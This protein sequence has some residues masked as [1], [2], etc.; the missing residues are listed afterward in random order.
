MFRL[1]EHHTTV[2][3][4]VRGGLVTFLTL[5]YI[6]FVQPAVMGA[7]GMPPG[8]V[9]VA[10]CVGSAVACFL[11][12]LLTNYPFALAP[13]MG[14]NFFFAF[15]VCG[16]VPVG[17]GFAWRE[18]LMANLLSG[19]VFLGLSFFGIRAA[20]MHAV[21]DGLKYA[22][23]VGIGLLIAFVGLQYGGVVQNSGAVLVR[24]GDLTS[25]VVLLV[26]GGIGLTAI[27]TALEFRG[28]IL[29]GILATAVAAC[30]LPPVAYHQSDGLE[31]VTAATQ[32][33]R[34]G[35]PD[36]KGKA[37]APVP[38]DQVR[39]V[40]ARPREADSFLGRVVA[41]PAWPKVTLGAVFEDPLALLRNH[42]IL[43]VLLVIFIFFFLDLF[44]TVGTLI[45]VSERA[46]FLDAQ[47]RLPRARW[48]LFA[49]AAGTV[50][51]AIGGT[52]TITTYVESAAGVREGART[53]LAAIVTGVL[54]LASLFLA[55]LVEMVGMG[56]HFVHAGTG[57]ALRQVVAGTP[58]EVKF[59]P[60][61]APVL[62]I[63][64]VMMM[65]SV[66]KIPWDDYSE[67][68]PAFLTVVVMQFSLSITDGIAWG[69]ISYALLKIVTGRT[70]GVHWLVFLFAVLFVGQYVARALLL[71]S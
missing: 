21:P 49:D 37:A 39:V 4:E 11:M 41:A 30:A 14:T 48:A 13:G 65:G 42:P 2:A 44:D 63:I 46:G 61:I 28:A 58:V 59:Y 69:F 31:C 70:R 60:V 36:F 53:G 29:A 18:A 32:L 43:N 5:S 55:P 24:L 12:G 50:V 34:A 45:G 62:V 3:A 38:A 7:A 9:F 23:A 66:R 35:V 19:V 1:R 47:G 64:G 33:D 26:L 10:T 51:G 15:M 27:L 71:R 22:I 56:A 52:S 67:A 40:L 54:L 6:L 25:P 20:V 8:D 57:E 17:M 68:I 16:A